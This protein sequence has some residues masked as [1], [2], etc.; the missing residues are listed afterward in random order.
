[1]QKSDEAAGAPHGVA[2]VGD[3]T[4]GAMQHSKVDVNSALL[5]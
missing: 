3:R 1:M 2:A 4:I 5:N